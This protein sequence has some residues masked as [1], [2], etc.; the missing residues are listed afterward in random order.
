MP[1]HIHPNP[2]DLDDVRYQ[3][4]ILPAT[5]H[6]AHPCDQ[7]A[8]AEGFGDVAV[9]ATFQPDDLVDL[10]VPGGKHDYW[11]WSAKSELTAHLSARQTRHH[12]VEQHDVSTTSIKLGDPGG[13]IPRLD[14]LEA[15]VGK[16]VGQGL[17]VGLLV[18]NH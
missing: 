5:Q 11:D 14:H 8:V 18:L 4:A 15:L 6:R 9:G 10:G 1:F 13:P 7:L 16:H 3:L 12:Q 17:S 2:G